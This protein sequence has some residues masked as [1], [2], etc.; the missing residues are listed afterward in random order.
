MHKGDMEVE[1]SRKL[2]R[3]LIIVCLMLI[4]G[5]Q[6]CQRETPAEK[7]QPPQPTS[8]V[9]QAAQ[10]AVD[11]IK[12]PLDKARGVEGTLGEAAERTA[13]RAKEATQ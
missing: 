7:T 11:A 12:T 4:V 9:D 1:M 10:Q 13:D 8:A 2:S 6:G 5:I 3:I